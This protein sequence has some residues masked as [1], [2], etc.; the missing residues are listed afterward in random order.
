MHPVILSRLAG[1][2]IEAAELTPLSSL[3]GGEA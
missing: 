3:I 2:I 1:P